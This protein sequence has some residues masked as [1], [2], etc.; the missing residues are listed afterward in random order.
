[1]AFRRA[2]RQ[3]QERALVRALAQGP[4]DGL[5]SPNNPAGSAIKN[6]AE[7]TKQ[8]LTPRKA[9]KWLRGFGIMPT[10]RES[11]RGYNRTAIL[12]AAGRYNTQDA[13]EASG[14]VI[15]NYRNDLKMTD[16]DASDGYSVQGNPESA[17]VGSERLTNG[18]ERCLG[19]GNVFGSFAGWRAHIARGRC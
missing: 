14:S 19:C 5:T 9:A 18:S 15:P 3:G 16:A 10:R 11:Y 7:S 6:T 8:N 12:D 13:S 2:V 17:H 1:L 4:L